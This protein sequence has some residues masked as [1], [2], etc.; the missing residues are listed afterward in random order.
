MQVRP[1]A[2]RFAKPQPAQLAA[3]DQGVCTA[4]AK[5]LHYGKLRRLTHAALGQALHGSNPIRVHPP[6]ACHLAQAY[7]QPPL[8]R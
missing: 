6:C 8:K 1:G 3:G 7:L 4:A 2:V 5:R